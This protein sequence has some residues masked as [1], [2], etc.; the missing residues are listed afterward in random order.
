VSHATDRAVLEAGPR[1]GV[2]PGADGAGWQVT[3][4]LPFEA[5]RGFHAVLGRMGPGARVAVKGAPEVLLPRCEWWAQRPGHRL[6][7]ADRERLG[8]EVERLAHRGLRVL[9]V[10]EAP[11]EAADHLEESAVLGLELQGFVGL[12]DPARETAA[13]AIDTL[14]QAGV[15][16]VMA[17]GD[18]PSTAAAIA[19]ELG[20]GDG[21]QGLTAD[22]L[23]GAHGPAL[24]AAVAG[25]P[26]FARVTPAD[27]VAIV[28]ALQRAGRVVAMTGDGA[29]DA[30][31]IRLAD[32]GIAVGERSTAAARQAADV[33][34]TDDHLETVVDALIEGRAMWASVR[35]ALAILVGGN[36]GEIGFTVGATA[37]TGTSPLT[38]RQLLL[39]NLFTDLLPAT[40]IALRPPPRATPE[41]LLAEG[42]QASLGGTLTRDIAIRAVATAGGTGLAWGVARLTG[43]AR[44]ARTVALVAL[45]ATQL[46]QTVAVGGRSPLVLGS[47]AVSAA[48]LAALVQTPGVSGRLG[49]VPLDPL[50]WGIAIGGAGVATCGSIVA[51][52]VL[53]VRPL[54]ADRRG[55]PGSTSSPGEGGGRGPAGKAHHQAAG[56][57]QD[58]GRGSPAIDPGG[59]R[60]G[61]GSP[62]PAA[63]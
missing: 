62:P 24:D 48:G 40:A 10:A 28:E 11:V 21:R 25:T 57:R 8:A 44:R 56:E 42:P 20:I 60:P 54:D 29:N 33:V 23:D 4:E 49:C 53:A 9:A 38:P 18:H 36:L 16:V 5:S 59:A 30:P 47:V 2:G 1:A 45:V 37:V 51:R 13:S 26:V 27:K 3:A 7:G 17:T 61:P 35:D 32:A 63:A 22:D 34:V 41:R 31:A 6:G 14:R 15:E 52:R 43:P 50:A 19:A 55:Y 12:A 46:G 39:V 58:S